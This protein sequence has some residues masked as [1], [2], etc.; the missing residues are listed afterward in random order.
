ML[1]FDWVNH[2]FFW[3]DYL[4]VMN[5]VCDLIRLLLCYDLLYKLGIINGSLANLHLMHFS[6]KV[7]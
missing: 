1:V 2:V 4:R 7:A 6:P 5:V 3:S